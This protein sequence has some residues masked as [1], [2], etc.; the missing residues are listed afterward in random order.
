VTENQKKVSAV[1]AVGIMSG[2]AAVAVIFALAAATGKLIGGTFLADLFISLSSSI[3]DLKIMLGGLGVL[4]LGG[5]GYFG[6]KCTSRRQ[7]TIVVS[8][9]TLGILSCIALMLSFSDENLVGNIYQPSLVGDYGTHETF[10]NDAKPV[11]TGV[12]AALVSGLAAFLGFS[13]R[14]REKQ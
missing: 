7:W 14:E 10:L 1:I 2:L 3:A 6:A 5:A 11:V 12:G 8:I 9:L 13:P 4:V